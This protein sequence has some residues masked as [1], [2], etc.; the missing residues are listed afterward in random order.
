MVPATMAVSAA[1]EG[2]TPTSL[3]T[4]C[5]RPQMVSLVAPKVV[6]RAVVVDAGSAAV[7]AVVVEVGSTAVP[8]AALAVAAVAGDSVAP[9]A[10]AVASVARKHFQSLSRGND[11]WVTDPWES[12]LAAGACNMKAA[13]HTP[14]GAHHTQGVAGGGHGP[15]PFQD[16]RRKGVAHTRADA[17]AA[18]MAGNA[19]AP[20]LQFLT[21]RDALSTRR[22]VCCS[23]QRRWHKSSGRPARAALPERIPR[24][25]CG[26]ARRGY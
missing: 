7:P 2:L 10:A 22:G 18:Q 19:Q 12:P 6:G 24:P 13:C 4:M 20:R 15:L 14:A 9:C 8:A 25:F 3:P 5:P 16:S 1:G 17:H 23:S 21:S 11:S 26:L